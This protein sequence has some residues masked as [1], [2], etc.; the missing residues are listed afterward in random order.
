LYRR[1]KRDRQ[2]PIPLHT[3]YY[4]NGSHGNALKAG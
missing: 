1:V 3:V 4:R 2:Y